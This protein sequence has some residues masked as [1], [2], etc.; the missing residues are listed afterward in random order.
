LTGP[1]QNTTQDQLLELQTLFNIEIPLT[2]HLKL[3]VA[4]YDGKVLKLNAPLTENVNHSGTAFAGSLNALLTLAGWGIVWFVLQECALQG[5]IVI[6]DGA[7]NYLR[8]VTT[9]FS[10]TCEKPDHN[11]LKRFEKT[12]RE[13]G[14]ARLELCAEIM[15]RNTLAV[16]FQGRYVV[17]LR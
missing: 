3:Q 14:K 17:H 12:L 5:E 16:S 13:R 10:A 4:N 2:K 1:T 9:D 15:E 6:Q 7:C 8:P 11:Q